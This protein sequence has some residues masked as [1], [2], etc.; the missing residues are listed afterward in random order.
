MLDLL[1]NFS[2]L[3]SLNVGGLIT[4]MVSDEA[5]AENWMEQ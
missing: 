2:P 4:L 5:L 1:D 3:I